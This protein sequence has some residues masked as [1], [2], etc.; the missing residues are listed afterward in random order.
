MK[1]VFAGKVLLNFLACLHR[2]AHK[3]KQRG[4]RWTPALLSTVPPV[5]V[6]CDQLQRSVHRNDRATHFVSI[7]V[8]LTAINRTLGGEFVANKQPVI[9][10]K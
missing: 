5:N 7:N 8:T 4:V 6:A 9:N 1:H 2:I 10:I 3:N